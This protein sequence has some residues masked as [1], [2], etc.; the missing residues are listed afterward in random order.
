MKFTKK[1]QQDHE[2]NPTMS[3]KLKFKFSFYYIEVLLCG[4]TRDVGTRITWKNFAK[5][6]LIFNSS[7]PSGKPE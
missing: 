3:L 5:Y 6:A 7:L 2:S 4:K 1:K